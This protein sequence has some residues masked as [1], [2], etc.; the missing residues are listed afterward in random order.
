[1]KRKVLLLAISS[2]SLVLGVTAGV[3]FGKHANDFSVRAKDDSYWYHYNQVT[4]TDFKH[5]SKEFWANCSTHSFSFHIYLLP[6][7]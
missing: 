1:M 4:P 3:L 7:L 2:A 5:G 6:A